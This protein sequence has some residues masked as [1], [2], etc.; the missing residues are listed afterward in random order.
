MMES[1][2]DMAN[3][4]DMPMFRLDHGQAPVNFSQ[5]NQILETVQNLKGSLDDAV[6]DRRELEK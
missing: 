3:I 5:I 4:L 2:E 6:Q 1:F